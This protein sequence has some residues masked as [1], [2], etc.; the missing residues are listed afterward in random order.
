MMFKSVKE[1]IL[2]VFRRTR[3]YIG[4]KS[5]LPAPVRHHVI[6][7][8]SLW[9]SG[10]G[11]GSWF[12]ISKKS[13]GAYSIVRYSEKGAVECRGYFD[14]KILI[15]DYWPNSIKIGYPSNC[16]VLTLEIEE[17]QAEFEIY[18]INRC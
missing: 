3:I 9:H 11:A 6:P 2:M 1:V 17:A 13:Q 16:R 4:T 14:S 8:G 10:E 7:E 5:V 15:E 18:K 12:Y